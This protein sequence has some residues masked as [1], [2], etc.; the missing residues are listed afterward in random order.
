MSFALCNETTCCC[1]TTPCITGGWEP[2]K[3]GTFGRDFELNIKND[4]KLLSRFPISVQ[5]MIKRNF[6]IRNIWILFIFTFEI[7]YYLGPHFYSTCTYFRMGLM[8]LEQMKVNRMIF[9]SQGKYRP[10]VINCASWAIQ[11]TW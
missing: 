3:C 9:L 8:H 7:F 10:E 2:K 1:F 5:L 11:V 6:W 4:Y